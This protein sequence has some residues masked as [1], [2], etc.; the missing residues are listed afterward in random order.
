[1]TRNIAILIV[2]V[3]VLL[4]TRGVAQQGAAPP[5][6]AGGTVP[7]T[8]PAATTP[9]PTPATTPAAATP[10]ATVPG[11]ARV[12][13]ADALPLDGR[14][15][16]PL[17]I[18]NFRPQSMLRV[19][20]TPLTRASFPA[21]DIHTH[22]RFKLKQTAQQLDEW[23][24]T[25][26]RENIALTVSLDATLGPQLGEHLAYLK[27]HAD[28]FIVFAHIDWKGQGKDDDPASWDCQRE[29]FARRVAK[30]LKAA[31]EQGIAGLK[32]FKD[33]GLTYKN[34]DGS[35]LKID[36]P[37]FD[38]IWSTCGQLGLPVIMHVAD[39]AAFFLPID[40]KN[41][42]WEELSRHPDWSFYGE[43]FPKRE[44][45][46]AAMLRVIEKHKQTTFIGAHVASNSEDLTTVSQWL[47]KHPNLYVEI[48][49][50]IAEL[51]R[52]PV[53]ARKFFVRYQDRILLGTDGPWPEDRLHSYWRFLETD[54]EYFPYSEKSFPPQGL[55]HIYGISLPQ[56]VLRKVYADNA[57][58]LI[59]PAREK[60]TKQ[61]ERLLKLH[62]PAVPL[63]AA[64]IPPAT[65][66]P[67]AVP[68]AAG[69]PA[70]P[71]ASGTPPAA[72]PPTAVPPTTPPPASPAKPAAK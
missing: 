33:F 13:S 69:T 64:V 71:P 63:P 9:A 43:K 42:R 12:K 38:E 59:P 58:K 36:D 37:R 47:D 23:V 24:A 22:L 50:R 11:A 15:G 52:Q 45:L 10:A 21:I 26:D 60:Y 72:N 48:A 46:L 39:P 61:A 17:A 34:A 56:E 65:T 28:R 5:V 32:I 44:D 7:S 4:A 67:A 40:E 68:P 18:E 55:W 35:Y 3:G 8:A 16:R 19:K 51:G 14:E 49:S 66:P 6:T 27:P 2:L 25:M 54:D 57:L 53:T 20:Q 1:M 30:D 29:D 62:P 41:E 70:A 31:K